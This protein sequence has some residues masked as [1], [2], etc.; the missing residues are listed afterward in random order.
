MEPNQIIMGHV[1]MTRRHDRLSAHP[2]ALDDE[3][4]AD[5]RKPSKSAR[6][7]TPHPSGTGDPR[8]QLNLARPTVLSS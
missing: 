3:H 7:R 5:A 1:R 8:Q 2:P 4:Q 6:R